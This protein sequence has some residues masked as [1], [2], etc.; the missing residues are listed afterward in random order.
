MELREYLSVRRAYNRV[1]QNAE[2]EGR[3]TFEE[4]A[5]LCRLQTSD[6]PVKTSDIASWQGAL[7]PTMTHRTNHL[8]KLGLIER[9]GGQVDRRNIVCRISTEGAARVGELCEETREE[10]PSGRPLSRTSSQRICRY[11]E[12]MGSLYCTAG[13]LVLIGLLDETT[14]ACTIMKLVDKLGLLQPTVSMSVAALEERGRVA[15]VQTEEGRRAA[16]VQITD[17]GRADAESLVARI[18]G[19]VVRRKARARK[20]DGKTKTSQA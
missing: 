13:D 17:L 15:R 11:V 8:A 9:A 10:I 19:L 5:I 7:R 12:A 20:G 6:V 16:L 18:G 2:A 1:R 14:G 3:L 4:F